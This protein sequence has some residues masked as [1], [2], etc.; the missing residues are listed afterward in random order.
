MKLIEK[1]EFLAINPLEPVEETIQ[2]SWNILKTPHKIV[3]HYFWGLLPSE[4]QEK[5]TTHNGLPYDYL[6]RVSCGGNLVAS[7][8]KF[9]GA[10]L[11]PAGFLFNTPSLFLKLSALG[12]AGESFYRLYRVK[13]TEKPFGNF[14]LEFGNSVYQ[15]IK[16]KI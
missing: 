1:L 13:K 11:I 6:T 12:V 8:I 9:S 7:L 3:E 4:Q 15:N 2:T 5:Y 16:G 10:M 14:P